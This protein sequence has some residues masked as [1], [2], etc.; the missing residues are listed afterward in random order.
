MAKSTAQKE[1]ADL[2]R[3]EQQEEEWA[4]ESRSRGRYLQKWL[5]DIGDM[6]HPDAEAKLREI[7]KLANE[8]KDILENVNMEAPNA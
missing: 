4:E 2:W 6:K 8:L 5:R 1:A 3:H 7:K